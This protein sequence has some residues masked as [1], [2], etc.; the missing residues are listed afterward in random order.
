MIE[1]I[2]WATVAMIPTGLAAMNG[3]FEAFYWFMNTRKDL[4]PEVVQV[5]SDMYF[6]RMNGVIIGF[7]NTSYKQPLTNWTDFPDEHRNDFDKDA[8]NETEEEEGDPFA[9]D[10]GNPRLQFLD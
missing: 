9:V 7:T 1:W 8:A 10:S 3:D 6:N 2:F 5:Q 4:L